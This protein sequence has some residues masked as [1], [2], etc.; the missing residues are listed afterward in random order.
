MDKAANVALRA[1]NVRLK[2]ELSDAISARERHARS[3]SE[4]AQR[5][6]LLESMLK[7]IP[8]GIVLARIADGRIIMGNSRVEEM[9]RHPVLYSADTTS[10]G[11]WVC[12]HEDGRR[13]QNDEFPLSRVIC[14]GE[15]YAELDA[16]YQRGDETLFWM[17]IIGRPVLDE[18]GERIGAAVALFDIDTERDLLSQQEVL[19]GEL[20]H[21]VKNAF[22]VVKS[23]VSQPLRRDPDSS[24]L[25]RNLD[26]RLDA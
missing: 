6:T 19:I 25:R 22:T 16:Q 9:L 4:I 24:E 15:D 8:V 17:R 13:V 18:R 5:V 11:E 23:I 3:A 14:E 12:F 10:Y 20:N 2:G 1:E 21:R 7:S 26:L